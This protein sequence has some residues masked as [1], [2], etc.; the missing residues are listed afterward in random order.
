MADIPLTDNRIKSMFN[1]FSDL[2][3]GNRHNHK[4][5]RLID[6][7]MV[8]IM[9]GL[10]PGVLFN[11]SLIVCI[12]LPII[13]YKYSDPEGFMVVNDAF[14]NHILATGS[15]TPTFGGWFWFAAFLTFLIL[16][17]IAGHIFFRSDINKA[18]EHDIKRRI[19]NNK[20]EIKKAI[21]HRIR[22][23]KTDVYT[24]IL[25][26]LK[27]ELE[28]LN[29]DLNREDLNLDR[30]SNTKDLKSL[31]AAIGENVAIIKNCSPSDD[32][33][34]IKSL[35]ILFPHKFI[36]PKTD[37][38]EWGYFEK[39]IDNTLKNCLTVEEK[40][41]FDISYKKAESIISCLDLKWDITGSLPSDT[42]KINA[43]TNLL[44]CYMI[45]LLQNDSGCSYSRFQKDFPYLNFYKY[46]L[47]RNELILLQYVDW[48]QAG[49]RTKNKIN[50]M[51]IDVQ[52]DFPDA[53]AIINKNESH[54]RMASSSWYVSRFIFKMAIIVCFSIFAIRAIQFLFPLRLGNFNEIFNTI[55][56]N[57]Q[58]T[59]LKIIEVLFAILPSALPPLLLAILIYNMRNQ[60]TKFI[61][62]QRLR[63]IYFTLYIY[64]KLEQ[65][66]QEAKDKD[67]RFEN[68]LESSISKAICDCADRIFPR[69]E[70]MHWR[71]VE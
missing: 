2:I 54:I 51:K 37:S 59:P 10:I 5:V 29:K 38:L 44:T 60:L 36:N 23:D 21:T 71:F 61:H 14:N 48:S 62:Y 12:V 53:Y 8:D 27:S 28:S 58:H 24:I 19:K 39:T 26:L 32:K 3:Q 1:S 40:Q 34:I 22:T 67:L 66:K 18:D 41:I 15:G 65:R 64:H 50:R 20:A 11:F 63:E 30:D 4:A 46:L 45:L 25:E 56:Y 69:N 47:K 49:A 55:C 42:S 31:L 35:F 16:S 70:D 13:I 6:E 17:Y 43:L 52:L 57:W 9:G 7:L 68:T 33:I